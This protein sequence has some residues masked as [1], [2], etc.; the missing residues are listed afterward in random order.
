M[1]FTPREQ[2]FGSRIFVASNRL[3]YMATA[4]KINLATNLGDRGMVLIDEIRD[5]F[6]YPPLPD[7]AGQHAPIR[8]EYYFADSPKKPEDEPPVKPTE[9]PDKQAEPDEEENPNADE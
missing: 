4:D 6:N 1:F 8:D 3:Q 2:A 7:G 9:T 5:L